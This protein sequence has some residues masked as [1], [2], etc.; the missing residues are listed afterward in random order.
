[1]EVVV[2]EE[3]MEV[4]EAVVVAEAATEDVR[5]DVRADAQQWQTS[6][7]FLRSR[8][9]TI[10]ASCVSERNLR[11]FA[12]GGVLHQGIEGVAGGRA[13]GAH[14]VRSGV[15]AEQGP[16]RSMR[17]LLRVQASPLERAGGGRAVSAR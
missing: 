14:G 15:Q 17:R 4:Q 16:K 11:A 6:S 3:E 5:A 2:E 12:Q 13:W 7:P 9:A 10:D 1:M 8:R